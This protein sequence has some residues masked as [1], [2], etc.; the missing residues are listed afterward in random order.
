MDVRV[1]LADGDRARA[2]FVSAA[3]QLAKSESERIDPICSQLIPTLL[4]FRDSEVLSS[5]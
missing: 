5:N 3:A 1:G 2:A 4:L